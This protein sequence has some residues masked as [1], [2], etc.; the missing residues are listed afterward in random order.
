MTRLRLLQDNI[1]AE[2]EEEAIIRKIVAEEVRARDAHHLATSIL[3]LRQKY[4][5]HAADNQIPY[6]VN[7]L[8]NMLRQNGSGVRRVVQ[9]ISLLYNK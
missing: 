2:T 4:Y 7:L 3:E 8:E 6:W 1:S 5:G 9:R